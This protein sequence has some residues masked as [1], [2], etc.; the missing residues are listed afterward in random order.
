MLGNANIQDAGS[1]YV[2]HKSTNDKG[3]GKWKRME[4]LME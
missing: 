2:K 4:N 3:G 1:Y